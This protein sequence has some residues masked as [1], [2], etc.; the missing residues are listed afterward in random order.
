M[1]E[2]TVAEVT[3]AGRQRVRLGAV[4]E[5]LFIPL[6]TRARETSKRRPVLRDPKAVEMVES[7]DYDTAKYGRGAGGLV[8]ILRTAIFDVWVRAFLAE[9]PAGTIVETGTGLNT[10]FERVDNGAV[11]WID[12]D[13]PDTIELRRR[14]FADKL[15]RLGLRVVESTTITRPPRALRAQLPPLYRYLLPL[16]DPL[17]GK[18]LKITVFQARP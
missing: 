13:L 11:R 14:F 17:L 4:Q 8:T 10:P 1:A 5:T 2:V 16:T 3:V 9:H 7:I 6:A 12:L 18:A 15:Q